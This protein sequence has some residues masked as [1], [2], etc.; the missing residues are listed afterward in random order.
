[1][2]TLID[3]L[4][5]Q[6]EQGK[7]T[8]RQLIQS[9]ALAAAAAPA[10]ASAQGSA[11]SGI[12]P[13]TGPA[14]WKTVWLDHISFNVTNYKETTAFYQALLGWKPTGD[15]GSQNETEIADIGNIIIRGGNPTTAAAGAAAGTPR[16]ARIDHCAFGISPWDTD[17][18]AKALA[19][20]GLSARAD[21]GGKGDIHDAKALYKSYHTQTPSGFDLQISNANLKNRT[22]R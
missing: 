17:G 11:A 14:P 10:A 12:P 5:K 8:R 22:V 13:S 4:L 18:V 1:M 6:F 16:H 20:R 3:G 7:M 21:T 19:D 2:E 15:E 9:L